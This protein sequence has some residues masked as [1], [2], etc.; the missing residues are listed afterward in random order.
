MKHHVQP[1]EKPI[2]LVHGG[3][4]SFGRRNFKEYRSCLKDAVTNGYEALLSGSAIEGVVEA[5]KI[6]EDCGHM[7]AGIGSVLNLHGYVEMDAGIMDG[8]TMR[9]AGV[10]LIR[11]IRNPILLAKA[12]MDHTDHVL[13]AG[14]FAEKL[15]EKLGL[16]TYDFVPQEDKKRKYNELYSKLLKGDI[17]HLRR[18]SELVQKYKD[19]AYGTVGA[20]A[21]D[22]E[23]RLAAATST[24]GYWL[25][26][27]GRIGDTPIVGAGF[28][29]NK[30]AAASST[31][32]GEYILIAGLCR[33]AVE[34]VEAGLNATSAA[35]KSIE[36]M[37][38]FF[39]ENTAGL[40]IVDFRGYVGAAFNTKGMG[41]AILSKSHKEPVIAKPRINGTVI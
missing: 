13:L 8:K 33:K 28:Y 11:K 9:A 35:V 34:F 20:V 3:A 21:L 4:G 36:Y 15:G 25:K 24:G 23:G 7:N 40:I 31:G 12:I 26:L 18:I 10:A 41:R 22:R 32:I 29:A 6:M 5:V 38:A 17:K 30:N 39:G 19:I 16:E 1:F 37:S 14:D 2:I 27:P